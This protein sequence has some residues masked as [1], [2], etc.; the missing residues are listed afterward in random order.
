MANKFEMPRDMHKHYEKDGKLFIPIGSVTAPQVIL[1]DA[2][3]G[4][5]VYVSMG[6]KEEQ[7]YTK[8]VLKGC[9]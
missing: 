3:T 2:L 5:S 4:E 6:S 8:I 9:K 1:M 7:S